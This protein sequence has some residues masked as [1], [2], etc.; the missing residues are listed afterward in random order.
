[1]TPAEYC[2]MKV[3]L[4][5]SSLYYSLWSLP[6]GQRQALIAL[7][8]LQRELAE[9]SLECQDP[10]VA[11]RKL[12]WWQE[13]MPRLFMGRARHPVTQALAVSLERFSLPAENLQTLLA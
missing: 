8:A 9:L 10:A 4:P 7:Y 1:M 11:Q 5:G 2:Q 12:Q 6:T 3:A 13:E